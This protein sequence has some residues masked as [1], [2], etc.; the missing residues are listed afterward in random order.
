M[1][2]SLLRAAAILSV[3]P[4]LALAQS[5]NDDD[6]RR[7]IRAGSF[8]IQPSMSAGVEYDT[9]IFRENV[10]K[11][12][13]F[14]LTIAPSVDI[15][16]DWNRHGLRLN[17][18]SEYG[19]YTNDNADDYFDYNAELAGVLDI[20]RAIR[21]S[22]NIGYLHGHEARGSDDVAATAL[23]TEPTE[24]DNISLSLLGEAAFGRF[25]VSP[26][27]DGR[28]R[29]FDD[30]PLAAGGFINNDDRD[31]LE[32]ETGVELSYQ[33]RSGFTAF[34]RPSYIA[35]DYDDAVDD[36]G[37]NRDAN[38]YRILAGMKVDLTR[39]IE[40]SVGVG[41]GSYDY[42]D[43]TLSDTSSLALDV[44][45]IWSITPRL[46]LT[47]AA[48]R[49]VTETTVAGAGGAIQL[50]GQVGVEYDLLRTVLLKTNAGFINVEYDG[51][52]RTDNLFSAGFG[53]DWS[54]TRDVTVSPYYGF[55]L[56][57][58]TAVSLGYRDHK[59]GVDAVYR[60]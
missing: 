36:T 12:E 8:R 40:A 25:V 32:I 52:A 23:A 43:P 9:N 41:Y 31:R 46:Q 44:Q 47:F 45:G 48:S 57:D 27:F 24:F 34:I 56:R 4:G 28:I 37:V 54:A 15:V 42:Q 22:G 2:N 53:V 38:G 49:N 10:N 39:L 33:V 19:L 50:G 58:T 55:S 59:V 7:G 18:G 35:V 13:S 29:D 60:F 3:L 20:S 21:L 16:S 26:F 17:L 14:I 6:E 1:K 30:V 11:N 5:A 51:T